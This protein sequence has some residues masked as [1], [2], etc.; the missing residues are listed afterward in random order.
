MGNT[1]KPANLEEHYNTIM[2]KLSTLRAGITF[3]TGSET[4][5]RSTSGHSNNAQNELLKE[6]K[7][8]ELEI[9]KAQFQVARKK[10]DINPNNLDL[11]NK[12]RDLKKQIKAL[13]GTL[14]RR[15][16]M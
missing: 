11:F 5:R 6:A 3:T 12:C 15:R 1:D 16:V 10:C 14:N 8:V 9:L 4:R 7:R 2:E 13:G